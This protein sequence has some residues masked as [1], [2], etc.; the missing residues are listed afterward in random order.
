MPK[1]TKAK[2]RSPLKAVPKPDRPRAS[3]SATPGLYPRDEGHT[4]LL[5]GVPDAMWQRLLDVSD[6]LDVS[7]RI[8]CIKALDYYLAANTPGATDGMFEHLGKPRNI[9]LR[10]QRLAKRRG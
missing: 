7:V 6:A 3:R 9:R 1:S 8:L 2:E 10:R 4:Y 5:A